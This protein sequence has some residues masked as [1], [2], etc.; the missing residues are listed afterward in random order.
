MGIDNNESRLKKAIERNHYENL[1]FYSYNAI[2][3]VPS[4][5]WNV[6]ILSNVL[7]HIDNRIEFLVKLINTT[8]AKKYLIRVPLF[9]RDWQIGL[10]KE[11]G[12][13][14]F[15]DDD[16]KIEHTLNEFELEI[17]AA[18]L[19]LMQKT[20]LWGEIWARCEDLRGV[21]NERSN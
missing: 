20:L 5:E 11:L 14:Y 1:S 15:S 21:E 17:S 19:N 3:K 8:Q 2:E 16:H 13:N 12:I 7:E 9:E 18:G 6:V 4:G 10:R